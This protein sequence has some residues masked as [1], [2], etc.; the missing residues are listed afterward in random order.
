V[1]LKPDIDTDFSQFQD[2][3][4]FQERRNSDQTP[5]DCPKEDCPAVFVLERRVDRH[6]HEI[7]ELKTMIQTNGEAVEK[8]SLATKEILE[9]VTLAKGFFKVLGWIGTGIKLIAGIGVPIAAFIYWLKFG[10][11]P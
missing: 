8:N 7:D 9:I 11:K 10:D 6:R 4:E 2:S 3:N 1:T 5:I